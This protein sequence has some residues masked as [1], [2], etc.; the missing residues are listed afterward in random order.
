MTASRRGLELENSP[1]TY[2]SLIMAPGKFLNGGR[3]PHKK[4]LRAGSGAVRGT[5]PLGSTTVANRVL[6]APG[7][8]FN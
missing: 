4:T 8:A 1:R 7:A 3:T 6:R 2:F 5:G